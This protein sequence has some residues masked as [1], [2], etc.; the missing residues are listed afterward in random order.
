MELNPY[1]NSLE[2]RWSKAKQVTAYPS[3]ANVRHEADK[4]RQELR[5]INP[6]GPVVAVASARETA[7]HYRGYD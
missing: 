6:A 3:E 1:P 7:Q 2:R 4:H 5:R